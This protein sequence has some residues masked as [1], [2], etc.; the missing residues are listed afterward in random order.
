LM[1]TGG[2]LGENQFQGSM[3]VLQLH[4]LGV[5]SIVIGSPLPATAHGTFLLL[6]LLCQHL[7]QYDTVNNTHNTATKGPSH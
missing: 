2:Y 6:H 3:V 4:E 1:Q 5:E 7:A